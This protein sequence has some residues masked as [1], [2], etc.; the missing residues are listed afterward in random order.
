MEL[1]DILAVIGL[2]LLALGGG[3][4][5]SFSTG[6]MPGLGRTDA[7][8]FVS[9][10]TSINRAVVNPLFLLPIFLPPVPLVWAGLI[11]SEAPRG[12]LLIAAGVVFLLGAIV[13]TIAGN[14]PLNNALE[15]STAT[16]AASRTAFERRWNVLNG[17]RS[18]ASFGALVL[19]ALALVL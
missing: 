17:V 3:T 14:V 8:T 5:W 13:V 15:S 6:V 4:F 10:M 16:A 7:D 19:A 12:W 11:S 9:A 2:V 1:T 18:A